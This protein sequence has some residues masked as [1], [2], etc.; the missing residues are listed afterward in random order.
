MRARPAPRAVLPSAKP[1]PTCLLTSAARSSTSLTSSSTRGFHSSSRHHRRL[2]LVW[3]QSTASHLRARNPSS[4]TR[5]PHRRIELSDSVCLP[6]H[7]PA[8]PSS[9][10]SWYVAPS[11]PLCLHPRLLAQADLSIFPSRLGLLFLQFRGPQLPVP[12]RRPQLLSP[13][14]QPA[15]SKPTREHPGRRRP[16]LLSPSPAG[17]W[18]S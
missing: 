11:S 2:G 13:S 1:P 3:R 6:I 9:N 7:L 17:P 5:F 12:R 15:L 4:I 10:S 16:G 14:Y 8:H 18:S